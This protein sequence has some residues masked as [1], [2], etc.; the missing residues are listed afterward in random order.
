MIEA[1]KKCYQLAR[2]NDK[3]L[4]GLKETKDNY[5]GRI[6]E[7]T[8]LY[9]ARDRSNHGAWPNWVI[10]LIIELLSHRTPPS[11]VLANILPVVS[12]ICAD[13]LSIINNLPGVSFVRDCHSLLVVTN[14]TL[15]ACQLA[16]SKSFD[17]L[18]TDSRDQRQHKI[19]NVVV[20]FLIGNGYN[21][22][23]L[24]VTIIPTSKTFLIGN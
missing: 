20:G 2:V 1:S 21:T 17:Q 15:A 12:L 6:R 19:D 22:V 16:K 8:P 9:S 23:V 7:L 18:C 3:L 4:T 10:Q 5:D 14:K 11:C 24:N 13:N